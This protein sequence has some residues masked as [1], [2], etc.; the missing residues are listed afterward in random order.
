MRERDAAYRGTGEV[1][2][3]VR[4]GNLSK[5]DCLDDVGVHGMI[6]LKLNFKK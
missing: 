6:I 2:T 5:R 1:N 3:G 4:W